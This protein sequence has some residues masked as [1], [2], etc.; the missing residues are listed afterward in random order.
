MGISFAG[1]LSVV[2]AGRP[3]IRDRLAFVYSFGG[4]G[5]LPRVLRYL[6]TGLEPAKPDDPPGAPV[7][8][9]PPHDY[10]VAV[11]LVGIADRMVPP[12][13][14]KPLRRGT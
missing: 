5:D 9:R 8:V 10:R 7:R 2:A 1:G 11:I 6:C 13:Q 14:V 3:S 4:H 12:E